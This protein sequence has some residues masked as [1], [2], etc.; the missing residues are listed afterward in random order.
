MKTDFDCIVLGL[1][2][3][4]A[5]AAYWLARRAGG[6]VL[7]L[8]QFDLGHVRGA[9]QDHSRII[10]LSY[11][12]PAYV[13]LAKQAY[14][15]WADVEA[16]AGEKLIVKMGGRDLSP[17]NSTIPLETYRASLTAEAVPFDDLDAAEVMRRWPA[18]PSFFSSSSCGI[19]IVSSWKMIEALM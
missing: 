16:D 14:S 19:T 6:D 18:S 9:S 3:I 11:H 2:G 15:A 12:T 8:E 10:R 4:G 17:A 7:G 5:A 1:G 13:A